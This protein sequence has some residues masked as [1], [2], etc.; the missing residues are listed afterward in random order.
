MFFICL[1]TAQDSATLALA[2]SHPDQ[3]GFS[4]LPAFFLPRRFDLSLMTGDY[5]PLVRVGR[6]A[7]YERVFR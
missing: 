2:L 5:M 4:A 6:S 3:A 1:T 7:F